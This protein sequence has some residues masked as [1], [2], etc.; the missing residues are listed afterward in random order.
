MQAKWRKQLIINDKPPAIP[1]AFMA[2]RLYKI[3]PPWGELEGVFMKTKIA[4]ASFI[5]AIGF[6][7]AG[8]I[9]P[10]MG[11]IDSSVLIFVAQLLTLTATFLGIDNYVNLIRRK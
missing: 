3:S 1:S 7:V 9:I 11:V 5:C 10:P 8:L 4:L 2:L 6:G